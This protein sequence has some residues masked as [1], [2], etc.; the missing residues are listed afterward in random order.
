VKSRGVLHL[1]GQMEAPV[2]WEYIMLMDEDDIIDFFAPLKA[3]AV[4]DYIHRS[5]ERW[6]LYRGMILGGLKLALLVAIGTARR[7]SAGAKQEEEVV[8]QVPPPMEK[9]RGRSV[10][11]RLGSKPGALEPSESASEGAE[12]DAPDGSE[13]L[14]AIAATRHGR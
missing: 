3:P 7:A 13:L 6:R 1:K 9:R 5:P 14:S 2:S 4:A 10:R 12:V 8:I 11:R